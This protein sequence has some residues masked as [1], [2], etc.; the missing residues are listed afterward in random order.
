MHQKYLVRE[1]G[2]EGRLFEGRVAAPDHRD[3]LLLEEGAVAR[4]APRDAVSREPGFV[5]EAEPAVRRAGRV[6]HGKRLAHATLAECD[7][8]DVTAELE[9]RDVVM[10]DLG[11]EALGLLP[12]LHHQVRPHDALGKS[13]EVL[14]VG[15][16]HEFATDVDRAG[17][18]QRLQSGAGRIDRRGVSGW[19]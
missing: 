16:L 18:E 9:F 13:G 12:H 6:D 11:A 19:P 10:D 14:D 7:A 5:V 17:D 3:G 2:Q 1:A 15:G 8:L 4:G